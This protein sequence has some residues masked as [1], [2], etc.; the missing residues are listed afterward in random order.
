MGSSALPAATIGAWLAVLVLI[1]GLLQ[2]RG[3]IFPVGVVVLVAVALLDR[4]YGT[5]GT[6]EV[7]LVSGA[8]LATAEFGYW[9]FE[10]EAGTKQTQ[11]VIVRRV[12]VILALVV[13]GAGLSATLAIMGTF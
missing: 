11:P 2:G 1:V 9:S 7:P 10:F 5:L 6:A 8:L 4:L 3:L 12:G 13:L